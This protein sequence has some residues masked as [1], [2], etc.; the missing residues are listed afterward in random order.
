METANLLLV[1]D[2]LEHL[3]LMHEM[4]KLEDRYK[5]FKASSGEEALRLLAAEEIQIVLLDVLMPEMDGYEVCRQIRQRYSLAPIQVLMISGLEQRGDLEQLLEYGA[6]DFIS[7]PITPLELSARVRAAVI[8]LQDHAQYLAGRA[9]AIG[10]GR[11][12]RISSLLAENRELRREYQKVRRINEDLERSCQELEMLASLDP[13]SGLLNRR[14]LFQRIEIEIERS[15]RLGLPLTGIMIDIDHFKRVNDNF[16]HPCGDMVIREI[17]ARLTRSLRKYDYAGRYGGEEFF[18]LFSNTTSELARSIA[19]RFRKD[20]EDS[21]FP[22]ENEMLK[23]TVSIGIS[24][25][26]PGESPERWISRA[27]AAMYRAKQRGRNQT[28]QI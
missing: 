10:D 7:K 5:L 12:G 20:V 23:L 22:W 16:G 9:A 17:G 27:D 19:E 26:I 28:E 25:Y 24:Q 8:R 14:T 15:L 11:R 18:V 4:L 13:L 6:D 2:N 3:N 21:A 1:D